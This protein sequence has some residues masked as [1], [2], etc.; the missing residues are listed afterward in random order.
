[1]IYARYRS[2]LSVVADVATILGVSFF[3]LFGNRI[4]SSALSRQFSFF[5][6]ITATLFY[7]VFVIVFLFSIG[8]MLKKTFSSAKDK[9]WLDSIL[10]C[11]GFFIVWLILVFLGGRLRTGFASM[12]NNEY[13]LPPQPINII[14]E[15][16]DLEWDPNSA[17]I[18]GRIAWKRS[19]IDTSKYRILSY[20][21]YS[22]DTHLKLH[23]F[24]HPTKAGSVEYSFVGVSEKG[25]F[26][27]PSVSS[28]SVTYGN[29]LERA[30]IAVVRKADCDFFPDYPY[31][32]LSLPDP[33]L[34][35]I[36]ASTVE[37][38][39]NDIQQVFQVRRQ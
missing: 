36:G 33:T 8:F 25:N 21:K 34:D 28:K 10:Y 12:L 5:D 26:I 17:E 1:M 35:S 19:H 3:T 39:R 37:L 9:R 6:F 38:P 31:G 7:F 22:D 2:C 24:W 4:L 15:I 11:I 18:R 27:V 32:I 29:Y 13:L 30:A 16:T 14:H 20:L 23:E